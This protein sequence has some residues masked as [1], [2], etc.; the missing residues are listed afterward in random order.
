MHIK[1]AE[2]RGVPVK[3]FFSKNL[4]YDIDTAED[5]LRLVKEEKDTASRSIEFLK[6]KFRLG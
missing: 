5:A 4:M 3:Y 2:S 6:S 1:T